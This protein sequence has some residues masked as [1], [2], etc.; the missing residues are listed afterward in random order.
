MKA[1]ITF[2]HFLALFT[3]LLVPLAKAQTILAP[4]IKIDRDARTA[5]FTF[6]A[7][8]SDYYVLSGGTDLQN[9][10]SGEGITLGAAGQM[11]FTANFRDDQSKFF[12]ILRA[13]PQSAPEDQDQDEINDLF[14]LQN[15]DVFNP[16]L[17]I[18]A[19]FDSDT[20]GV[21]NVTEVKNGTN[22]L[23][24][25]GM[26]FAAASVT[27]ASPFH[28]EEMVSITRQIEVRLSDRVDRATVTENNLFLTANGQR[29]AGQVSVS[30]TE[31]TL[32]FQPAAPFSPSTEIRVTIDGE[33]I[34]S[35]SGEPLDAD[36]D[37][38]PGG[39]RIIDFQTL[40]LAVVPGTNVF[41]FVFDRLATADRRRDHPS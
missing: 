28:G 40:P 25:D 37:G 1:L 12:Y 15:P 24:P 3:L 23:V 29:L 20:D 19:F 36:N 11:S 38:T 31:K 10:P 33:S 22:P 39:V 9:F 30:A 34:M 6:M 7:N 5:E 17:D 16:F 26:A 2:R 21:N 35:R 4:E 13:I 8:D 18:D 41:G 14:E 27:E 32:T